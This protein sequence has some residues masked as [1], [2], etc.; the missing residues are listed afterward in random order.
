MAEAVCALDDHG[1]EPVGIEVALGVDDDAQRVVVDLHH[2]RAG[3]RV[4]AGCR[5]AAREELIPLRDD[6][7]IESET[8]PSEE[9]TGSRLRSSRVTWR[10]A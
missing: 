7:L 3:E 5:I 10:V 9:A 2:R 1:L 6:D 4:G 8:R